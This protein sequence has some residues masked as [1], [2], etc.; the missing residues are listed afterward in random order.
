MGIE[1]LGLEGTSAVGT[2]GGLG[3]RRATGDSHRLRGLGD[4]ARAADLGAGFY[5]KAL[6]TLSISFAQWARSSFVRSAAAWSRVQ[7]TY[8]FARRYF[9]NG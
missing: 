5:F 6:F 8:S 4:V 7:R 1:E 2:N 3:L 9:E